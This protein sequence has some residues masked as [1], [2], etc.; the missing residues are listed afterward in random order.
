[1]NKFDIL[2]QEV[3]LEKYETT[4]ARSYPLLDIF[5]GLGIA[6]GWISFIWLLVLLYQG[7]R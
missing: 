6:F 2:E 7:A 1:M 5:I 3:E 4:N